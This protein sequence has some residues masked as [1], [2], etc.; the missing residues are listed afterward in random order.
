MIQNH[1]NEAGFVGYSIDYGPSIVNRSQ[2]EFF[3]SFPQARRF[4][5]EQRES[6]NSVGV[7]YIYEEA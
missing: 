6:G 7:F 1:D 2:R 3:A 4:H 5:Q